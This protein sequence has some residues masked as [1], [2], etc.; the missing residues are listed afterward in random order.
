M[1]WQ[2]LRPQL[3]A[4]TVWDKLSLIKWHQLLSWVDLGARCKRHRNP[5]LVHF[6]A[7]ATKSTWHIVYQREVSSYFIYLR[8]YLLLLPLWSIILTKIICFREPFF[9]VSLINL[10]S[11]GIASRNISEKLFSRICRDN[12]S[13]ETVVDVA[14]QTLLLCRQYHGKMILLLVHICWG[15][16]IKSIVIKWN[17]TDY[18]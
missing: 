14:R 1:P 7:A 10:W 9:R 15:K 11:R 5:F 18:S 8:I 12:L 2:T 3:S 13:Q 16:G 17:Q 4:R 6:I